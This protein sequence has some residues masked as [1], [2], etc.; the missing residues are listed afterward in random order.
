[1]PPN[2]PTNSRLRRSFSA[3]PPPPTSKY[4]PPSLPVLV[5]AIPCFE[6]QSQN[7]KWKLKGVNLLSHKGALG[8]R[9]G[10]HLSCSR[11]SD[12]MGTGCERGVEVTRLAMNIFRRSPPT[13]DMVRAL[14][15][16]FLFL[17]CVSWVAGFRALL[18]T[19]FSGFTILS[20]NE[21][22]VTDGQISRAIEL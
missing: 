21:S 9:A 2:P 20:A 16:L 17:V 3:P 13:L 8:Q 10:N 1:M 22:S 12:R 14:T 7:N 15:G 11:P 18:L 4:V 5:Q 19:V 6:D